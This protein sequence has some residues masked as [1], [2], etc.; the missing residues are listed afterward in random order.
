M[1]KFF[2]LLQNRHEN[3]VKAT[4]I[5]LEGDDLGWGAPSLGDDLGWGGEATRDAQ[6]CG[7]GYPPL[8]LLERD[9]IIPCFGTKYLGIWAIY[10]D[11]VN[12]IKLSLQELSL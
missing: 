9:I 10:F 7:G 2:R 4:H 8:G 3:R 6:G 1:E 11:I 12:M 5:F